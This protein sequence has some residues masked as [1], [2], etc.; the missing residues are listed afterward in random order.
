MS[1]VRFADV[2]EAARRLAGVAAR[3]PVFASRTLDERAGARVLL[4]CESFQRSGSFK[5]RGAYNAISRLDPPARR[6]GVAAF[7]SGNHAQGVA[8]AAKLLGAPAVIVMPRDAPAVKLEATRGYGAEIVLYERAEQSR[9]A[10]ARRLCEERGMTLVPPF[11]HP[12]IVAGQG[13]A[14]L[15]LVD[16]A[17]DLDALVAPVGGGGL[18]A[19]C[20]LAAR[21]RRPAIRLW[22]VEPQAANDT[23]LSLRRGERV[24]TAQ[25][26]SIA[27]GLLPTSPGE[28]TFPIL[29][30]H[31]EDVV[32][33]SEEEIV[34]A[35]RFLFLRM[36]IVVEPSGAAPV[37]ALLAGKIEA[38]RGKRVGVIVSG[39]NI[40]PAVLARIAAGRPARDGFD[41]A[42]PPC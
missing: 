25:A 14:G 32:L 22:G 3:T 36:K 11:D 26:D 20:A 7:S 27:D 19:G 2:E 15:E 17:P 12:M 28:I 5:F 41:G 8:L 37:A 42:G 9:E 18:L 10:I 34:E 6:R 39:G 33:V 29:R 21:A 23:W 16:E 13:T 24:A 4:K 31:L 38:A 30:D 1:A 40:D 35:V